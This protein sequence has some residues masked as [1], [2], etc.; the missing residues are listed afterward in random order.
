MRIVTDSDGDRWEETGPGWF[1]C[2]N[3]RAAYMRPKALADIR[4]FYGPIAIEGDAPAP[5]PLRF[6][7]DDAEDLWEETEPGKFRYKTDDGYEFTDKSLKYIQAHYG[8][9]TIYV[10]VEDA[11]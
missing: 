8:P 1:K 7:K 2:L 3:P 5:H 10:P 9:V 11:E 4:E 6:V